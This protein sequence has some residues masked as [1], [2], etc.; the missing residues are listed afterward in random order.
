MQFK[1][2]VEI[3]FFGVNY[4]TVINT[5]RNKNINVKDFSGYTHAVVPQWKIT[6]D[7]SVN[8]NG[9]GLGK[10]LEL[11][12]PI[13]YGEEGLDE[14]EIVLNT[15]KALGAKVDKT[16]GVH[17]HHD[18]SEFS[19]HDFKSLFCLYSYYQPVINSFMPK[20]RRDGQYCHIISRSELNDIMNANSIE[21][22]KWATGSRYRVLNFQSYVKY[23][24]IEFRQHSGSV[25]FEKI[26]AWILL[27]H[28]MLER[29]YREPFE[30]TQEVTSDFSKFCDEFNI[31]GHYIESYLKHRIEVLNVA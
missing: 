19:L 4:Q 10:G 12:S 9:T 6:T 7:C 11:V 30:Y 20:S 14:L 5:L 22:L 24:T 23:G 25:E 18:V 1:F 31:D 27:T 21:D 28:F 2:G 17:V 26:E 13:L 8:S 29:A 16:C 15:I 3:E